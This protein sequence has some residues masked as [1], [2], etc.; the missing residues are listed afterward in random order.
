MADRLDLPGCPPDPAVPHVESSSFGF[1]PLLPSSVAPMVHGHDDPYAAYY[2]THMQGSA[3]PYPPHP[4]AGR[5]PPPPP[6]GAP[7]PQPHPG[8]LPPGPPP[9]LL[10]H[11]QAI[12]APGQPGAYPPMQQHYGQHPP[13]HH[14]Q[15]PPLSSSRD[16]PPLDGYSSDYHHHHHQQQHQQHQHQQQQQQQQHAAAAASSSTPAMST[17]PLPPPSAGSGTQASPH[18]PKARSAMACQ[19]CRRQSASSPSL[20]QLARLV[21]AAQ[22]PHL[23][24]H[25]RAEMKCE[26]PE[27]APCRRC[28]AAQ[29]ECVFEAPPAAPPRP[30]GTGVTEAWVEGCVSLSLSL[31]P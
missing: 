26:G 30:R 16:G 20:S 2:Q 15:P 3:P 9:P 23:A 28:R 5:P 1:S 17:A 18:M 21:V 11:H 31:P 13:P 27:K 29:V 6:L 22:H 19:L 10:H 12:A 4:L 24:S 25:V 7:Q 14:H 8:D